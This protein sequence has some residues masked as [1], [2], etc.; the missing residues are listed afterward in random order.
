MSKSQKK[1]IDNVEKEILLTQENK[2]T[3]YEER[4]IKEINDSIDILTK[5]LSTYHEKTHETKGMIIAFDNLRK[6]IS[7]GAFSS[8]NQTNEV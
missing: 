2:K 8:A 1:R 5:Q 3:I 7:Q 4:L 6:S